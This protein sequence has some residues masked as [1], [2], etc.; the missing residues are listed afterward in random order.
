LIKK[1]LLFSCLI[2]FTPLVIV[3]I[4]IRNEEITFNFTENSVVRV[5]RESIKKIDK[6]PIEEYVVGVVAGEMPIDFQIEALKAQAVAAR[7]YVMKQIEKNINN[8]YDVVD[9]VMNQVYLDKDHL[10]SVWNSS[11]TENINKIKLAVLSTKGEY[12]SYDGKVAEAL[13]FST[14][15]GITENSE[16]I[17]VSKEPY[18]RSV[19]STWDEISPVYNINITYSLEEFY[20]LLNLKYQKSLK[21][22]IL[23]STSTGRIKKIEINN[24]EL[25][26]NYICSKLSLNSTYFEIIQEGE[27][28]IIK[29]KGYGHG[30]GMSQYGAEGMA[31]EGYT[32]KDILKYYYKNIEIK[33]I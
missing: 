25:T 7:S 12:L 32:Y 17:F 30:V 33:K 18:L 22:E 4:F 19:V 1:I 11:Y 9:T 20:K 16:E 27:K 10:M 21:I 31:R 23:E 29:N 14:S 6:V 2:V 5:Y 15:P 24:I 8:E 13:F 26:G 3:S 28:V